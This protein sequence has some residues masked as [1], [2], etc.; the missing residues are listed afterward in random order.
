MFVSLVTLFTVFVFYSPIIINN[1]IITLV[2]LLYRTT[3][4]GNPVDLLS[5]VTKDLTRCRV[6][7][8][9]KFTGIPLKKYIC[10]KEL[11]Q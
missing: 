4:S 1:R 2:F 7:V 6:E 11:S 3:T 5:S 9:G 8:D 10:V